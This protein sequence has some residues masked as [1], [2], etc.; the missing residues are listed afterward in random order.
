MGPPCNERASTIVDY[1]IAMLVRRAGGGDTG[2]RTMCRR[3]LFALCFAGLGSASAGEPVDADGDPL[4]PGVVRRFG[5]TRY[6]TAGRP[7]DLSYSPDGKLLAAGTHE[8]VLIWDRGTG[9]RLHVLR[10]HKFGA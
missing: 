4:P 6:R 1:T 3:F 7:I 5:S 8:G 2:F 9:K 10:G